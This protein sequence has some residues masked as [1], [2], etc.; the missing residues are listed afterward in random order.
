MRFSRS[1]LPWLHST[2]SNQFSRKWAPAISHRFTAGRVFGKNADPPEEL[3]Y[4]Q[5]ST[6]RHS[7]LKS[8]LAHADRTGL[9]PM[10]TV[11]VGTHYEYTVAS[12]LSRYGIDAK[13]C[14]GASDLGVDLLGTWKIPVQAEIQ[15]PPLR[16]ILQ[17]KAFSR[18]I[19]PS[20]IREL[21]GSFVGAPVGWRGAGVLALL[22]T[23]GTA[24]KGVRD[25]LG[26][27]NWPMGFISCS[28]DGV[29]RQMLWNRRAE[30]EGLEGLGVGLR[31]T[32]AVDSEP[33]IILTYKDMNVPLLDSPT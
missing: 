1:L 10:S 25:S 4:P 7:D 31:Y 14:G 26:R 28:R 16:V 2:T 32:G 23:E 27:S 20:L 29:V 19:G 15:P 5:P 11:Y 12:T 33:E 9:D 30:E 8:F 24:T 18:R 21:E 6:T 3:L 17:C 13:R 22:V